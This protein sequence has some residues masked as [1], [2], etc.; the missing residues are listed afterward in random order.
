MT[1][2]AHG[3]EAARVA[4]RIPGEATIVACET[5]FAES[6]LAN[7][8]SL[9]RAGVNFVLSIHF[10]DVRARLIRER[11]AALCAQYATWD[12]VRLA[13]DQAMPAIIATTNEIPKPTR[14]ALFETARLSD[15]VITRSWSEFVRTK[16]AL[17]SLRRNV[18]IVVNEDPE[19]PTSVTGAVTDAVVYAP[20]YR[21]DELA[22]FV[23]A[24]GDLEVPVT[25]V[26]RDQPTI[27]TRVR[28]VPPGETAAA[29][30]RA[31]VI[32]D[33]SGNDPGTALALAKLGRPL[34]VS[35][36]N[37]SAEILR[38]ARS[39]DLW[40]RRSILSAV[41]NG[42]AADP[43]VVRRG[44]YED[45]PQL[46]Q[47]LVFDASAPLVSVIV[48]TYNRPDLLGLTLES[49]QRQT[50]PALEI[51]V[52][53]DAGSDVSAVVAR[54]PRARLVDQPVNRGPSAA[55]NRGL[56]EA[57][58]EFVIFF[59]DDDEMFPNHIAALVN[60][61]LRSGLDVAYGQMINCFARNVGGGR[62]AVDRLDSHVALMD[63]ADIQWAGSLATTALMFRR[64]LIDAMGP[65]D[66]SL[67]AAEDYE[68][69]LRLATGREWARVPDI[70]SMY[71]IRNDGTNRSAGGAR[72]Y[73]L[74]HQGIYAKHPTTRPL[75]H[76]GRHAMLE[77]FSQTSG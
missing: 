51:V 46:R 16:Q 72:K 64:S 48:P 31:R 42:F 69:W 24:L 11:S 19:I 15:S 77:L 50:Y 54:F 68:F 44:H 39:Y 37:G 28:F 26:A 49:I 6:A 9:R 73:L 70:T 43:P 17:Y 36:F 75:V 56:A 12:E 18:D 2:D 23:T 20:R 62:Y 30:G 76:A 47:P 61:L 35:S 3:E 13:F 58:G 57:R 45:R 53:N 55:R 21:A 25:I 52:V 33:A 74:A 27:P 65:I 67:P 10:E 7:G 71:F 32:V 60:V 66:E 63:H 34:V 59:D 14:D 29:L 4:G 8:L 41:V 40:N 5:E 1:L 38:S 22:V